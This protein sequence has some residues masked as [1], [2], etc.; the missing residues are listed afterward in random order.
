MLI[1]HSLRLVYKLSSS[2]DYRHSDQYTGSPINVLFNLVNKITKG[3][4]P[5]TFISSLLLATIISNFASA[6]INLPDIGDPV[7][8]ILSPAEEEK[9]GQSFMKYAH[10]QLNLLDDIE[11]NDY[12]KTVGYRLLSNNNLGNESFHFFSVVDNS[13]NAF[14]VP[15][16]YIALNTGLISAAQNESQMAGVLAHEI[17]H[18]T[19]R[20]IARRIQ[21]G[22]KQNLPLMAAILFAIMGGLSDENMAHA[23][24]STSIAVSAQ[25]S[26]NFTRKNEYEADRIGITLLTNAGYSPQGMSDFF[27][28]LLSQNNL[29]SGN[30]IEILQTHPLGQN[31]IAEARNRA[32]Q[33]TSNSQIVDTTNF[34]LMKARLHWLLSTERQQREQFSLTQKSALAKT[35]IQDHYE[36]ALSALALE[37]TDAAN[38]HINYL[39]KAYPNNLYIRL[40]KAEITFSLISRQKGEILFD[41]LLKLYPNFSPAV[42]RYASVLSDAKKNKDAY[43]I[44]TRHIRTTEQTLPDFF[45]FQA[46][47]AQKAGYKIESLE[48]LASYHLSLNQPNKAK[49]Q[50]E[51][52]LKMVKKNSTNFERIDA[53]LRI[54]D[55]SKEGSDK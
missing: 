46:K 27:A 49:K 48:A 30:S 26:I 5:A 52:A 17:A 51:I 11:I 7:D 37:K 21:D 4:F 42:W 33:L 23:A 32:T 29:G 40:L 50:L 41:D 35:S 10:H 20:H 8:Q 31:R 12:I 1:Y 16:G 2:F 24:I 34:Q 14:A 22:N 28:I 53:R 6:E 25:N 15:G 9:I 19:Q 36:A 43:K 44:L 39:Q 55:P 18:I 13:I 47:L 38:N 3:T 54:I 45:Q